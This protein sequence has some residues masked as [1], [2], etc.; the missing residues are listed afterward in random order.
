M[1]SRN[2]VQSLFWAGG[3]ALALALFFAIMLQVKAV[4]SDIA[5][6]ERSIIAT[7]KQLMVLE[8]EF[9]TRARQQ[10]LVQWN[11]VDFGYTAPRAD[12]FV[13]ASGSLAMLGRP[14]EVEDAV[15]M[16]QA[17]VASD[18]FAQVATQPAERPKAA[19]ASFAAASAENRVRSALADNAGIRQLAAV[20]EK[21]RPAAVRV[22]AKPQ[23]KVETRPSVAAKPKVAEPKQAA[24]PPGTR[25]AERF[26]LDSVIAGSEGAN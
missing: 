9:Q 25:F 22:E 3:V 4:N 17:D 1:I 10:Q 8:T 24:P 18:R 14:V 26:D 19:E 20:I 5:M 12:Q 13:D 21:P 6:T 2:F 23:A 15:L 16:A 7:K 11:Q